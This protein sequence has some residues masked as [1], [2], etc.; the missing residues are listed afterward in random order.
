VFELNDGSLPEYRRRHDAIWPEMTQ[1][2]DSAGITNF[3][4]FAWNQRF[5]FAVLEAHPDFATAN[6]V[7]RASEVQGDWEQFMADTIAWQLDE[8]GNLNL[9]EE[10]FRHDGRRL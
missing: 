4:I 1:L 5:V 6:A 7:L 2:L 8:H 3:S 10:V 9:L